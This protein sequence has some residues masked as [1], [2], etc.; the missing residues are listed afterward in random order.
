MVKVLEQHSG[1]NWNMYHGDCVQVIKGI[2]DNS[3]GFIMYSP[4]FESLYT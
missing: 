3:I 4:P 1:K 2:P